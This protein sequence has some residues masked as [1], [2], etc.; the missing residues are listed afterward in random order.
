VSTTVGCD[1]V[2]NL[3][4]GNRHPFAV[5]FGEQPTQT[6]LA[7]L[8]SSTPQQTWLGG[9]HGTNITEDAQKDATTG[10]TGKERRFGIAVTSARSY[11]SS[12]KGSLT[13]AF[14]VGCTMAA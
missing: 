4:I 3:V 10:T 8:V 14:S 5:H 7:L 9:V 11:L 1:H 6:R 2:V 12:E 13:D